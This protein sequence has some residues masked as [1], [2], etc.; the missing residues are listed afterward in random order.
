[1]AIVMGSAA[2]RG[3][4]HRCGEEREEEKASLLPLPSLPK[5]GAPPILISKKAFINQSYS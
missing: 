4:G 5:K 2:R 1:M 3:R